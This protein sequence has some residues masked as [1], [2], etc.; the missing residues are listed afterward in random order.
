M[1]CL[2]VLRR[3]DW[4][5]F[6][7]TGLKACISFAYIFDNNDHDGGAKRQEYISHDEP[8]TK[9]AWEIDVSEV[10]SGC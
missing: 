6:I 5:G 8:K 2:L 4:C 9:T 1:T 7:R 10:S 3:C